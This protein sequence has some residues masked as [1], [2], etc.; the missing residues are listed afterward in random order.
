MPLLP[1]ICLRV[2]YF[3]PPAQQIRAKLLLQWGLGGAGRK[4]GVGIRKGPLQRGKDPAR[5]KSSELQGA[6]SNVPAE[7]DQINLELGARD[8]PP[9][10][11]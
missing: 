6:Q 4:G 1:H 8:A 3:F 5:R 11:V 10:S 9:V 2:S 7:N